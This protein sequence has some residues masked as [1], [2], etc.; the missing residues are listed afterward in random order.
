VGLY[1]FKGP[2]QQNGGPAHAELQE[3]PQVLPVQLND[4]GEPQSRAVTSWLQPCKHSQSAAM[5]SIPQPHGKYRCGN[6]PLELQRKLP[7]FPDF[8]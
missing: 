4:G 2:V 8:S 5:P 3:M 6:N 7:Q 1:T